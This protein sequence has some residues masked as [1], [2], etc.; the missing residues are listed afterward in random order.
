VRPSDESDA[1]PRLAEAS[2]AEETDDQAPTAVW[3]AKLRRPSYGEWMR[4]V[5]RLRGGPG[6]VLMALLTAVMVILGALLAVSLLGLPPLSR[7]PWL[8]LMLGS[9]VALPVALVLSP[10][11]YA[12]AALLDLVGRVHPDGSPPALRGLDVG[13][14]VWLWLFL[15][16]ASWLVLGFSYMLLLYFIDVIIRGNRHAREGSDMVQIALPLVAAFTAAACVAMIN[17][18]VAARRS[19]S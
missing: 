19:K 11:V 3:E 12:L 9:F 15:W 10:I 18:R 7:S 1:L 6:G 16:V 5:W 8:Q 14:R 13:Q 2:V 4:L 17:A